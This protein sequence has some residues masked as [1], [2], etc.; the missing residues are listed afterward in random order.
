MKREVEEAYQRFRRTGDQLS[1]LEEAGITRG[2]PWERAHEA[3]REASYELTTLHQK[4][5]DTERRLGRPA[6][7]YGASCVEDLDEIQHERN[8][9]LRNVNESLWNVKETEAAIVDAY[10]NEQ[11]SV[12]SLRK[13]LGWSHQRINRVLARHGVRRRDRWE[14]AQLAAEKRRGK[15]RLPCGTEIPANW[16]PPS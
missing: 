4:L 15:R 14:A 2:R 16:R 9:G 5:A 6:P 11:E 1:A 13:R 8:E 7:V 10:V 12:H 3:F